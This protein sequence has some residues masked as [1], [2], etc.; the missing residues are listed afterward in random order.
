MKSKMSLTLIWIRVL[1]LSGLCFASFTAFLYL[2]HQNAWW[3]AAT[4]SLLAFNAWAFVNSYRR[5]AA[6][7]REKSL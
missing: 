4:I 2:S 6:R 7:R 3:R 1:L 5:R